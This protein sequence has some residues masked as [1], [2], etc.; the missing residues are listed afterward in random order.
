MSAL[1]QDGAPIRSPVASYGRIR[2]EVMPWA[3]GAMTG[4]AGVDFP[5]SDQSCPRQPTGPRHPLSHLDRVGLRIEPEQGGRPGVRRD[6]SIQDTH[7]GGFARAVAAEQADHLPCPDRG[8]DLVQHRQTPVGFRQTAEGNGV[9][10][11]VFFRSAMA[12]PSRFSR[13]ASRVCSCASDRFMLRAMARISP[14]RRL[15]CNR[16]GEGEEIPRKEQPAKGSDQQGEGMLGG[17]LVAGL[18]GRDDGE[19]V[20]LQQEGNVLFVAYLDNRPA[21]ARF[22]EQLLGVAEI[23]DQR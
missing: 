3:C 23:P 14:D 22:A 20:F 18:Q 11:Q 8:A 1:A 10:G 17:G 6:H 16:L 12:R 2:P 4:R 19:Q 21:G 15:T 13:S 9:H 5:E 7:E